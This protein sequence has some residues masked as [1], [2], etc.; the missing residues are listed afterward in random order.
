M[1]QPMGEERAQTVQPPNLHKDGPTY[2]TG[3]LAYKGMRARTA[4]AG[5]KAWSSSTRDNASM[6]AAYTRVASQ[7][8][9][10]C[11]QLGGHLEGESLG[12]A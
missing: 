9:G 7:V 6:R 1:L 2:I 8:G 11:S 10:F 5:P 3:D 12:V 4:S